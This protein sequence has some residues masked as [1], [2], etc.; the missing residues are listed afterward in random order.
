[1]EEEKEF[2]YQLYEML[3]RTKRVSIATLVVEENPPKLWVELCSGE[4]YCISLETTHKI[5]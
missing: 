3:N 5:F 2:L 4:K 1:M